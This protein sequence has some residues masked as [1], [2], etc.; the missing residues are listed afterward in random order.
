[1]KNLRIAL[2]KKEKGEQLL[3]RLNELKENDEVDEEAYER[4]QEQYERLIK[5]GETEIEAIRGALSTK[6]AS[7]QRDLEKYPQEL[8]DLELKSKLGEIDASTFMKQDQKL[9]SR[10]KKLED[11]AEETKGFLEAE[12]AE[13]AGGF[14]DVSVDAKSSGLRV[15][16]WI[17]R[18]H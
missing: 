15:P 6:L 5:E 11:D 16:D 10:I 12:T 9:R 1:M 13:A 17:R 14:V 7:L 8:K 18:K 3:Q 4:K 2:S